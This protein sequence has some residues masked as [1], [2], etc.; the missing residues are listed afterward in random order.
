MI[1]A[2]SLEVLLLSR[3]PEAHQ[4]FLRALTERGI[5]VAIVRDPRQALH[6]L[7][8]TPVVVLVDLV[9]GAGLDRSSV[10]RLNRERGRSLVVALHQGALDD[11][12]DELAELSVDGFCRAGNWQPIAGLAGAPGLVSQLAH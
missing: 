6:D 8:R 7:R 5:P 12:L 3:A 9:H 4:E 2:A 10:A 11:A 1:R